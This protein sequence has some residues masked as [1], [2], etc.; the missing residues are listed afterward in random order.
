[1]SKAF[2]DFITALR[3]ENITVRAARGALVA[4]DVIAN[5]LAD[6][7]EAVHS[8][9][10]EERIIAAN[11][12]AL[13][14]Y[15]YSLAELKGLSIYDLYVD[16]EE[17]RRGFKR[18]LELGRLEV[19]TKIKTKRGELLSI[20]MKSFAL[21]D[22]EGNFVKTISMLRDITE[23]R[24]LKRK[25]LQA[26]RFSEMGKFAAGLAHDIRSPLTVL[27]GFTDCV[28]GSEYCRRDTQVM[29]AAGAVQRAVEKV[30]RYTTRLLQVRVSGTDEAMQAVNLATVVS[31]A[32]EMLDPKIRAGDVTIDCDVPA[33]YVLPGRKQQLEQVFSNIISNACDAVKGRDERRVTVRA[34]Q[35]DGQIAVSIADTGPGVEGKLRTRIFASFFTTKSDRHGTGI[36]LTIASE[37]VT[38]HQGHITVSSNT[39]QGTVFTVSLPARMTEA[40]ASQDMPEDTP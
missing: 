12:R 35:A 26:S 27:K 37:I 7:P 17:T 30:E 24:E 13:Q 38:A 39:P 9:N 16:K 15:G 25:L 36:G 5:I 20:K 10:A 23:Q 19:F 31:E 28:L 34:T 2:A 6:L 3:S 11:A 14:L 32:L 40:R 4:D 33:D 29:S 1:M 18:L 8:V 22:R 21:F